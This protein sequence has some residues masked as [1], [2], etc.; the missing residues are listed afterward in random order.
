VAGELNGTPGSD[1]GG[2]VAPAMS[3]RRVLTVP[4]RW[5]P[6]VL[7]APLLVFLVVFFLVPLGEVAWLSISEPTFGFGHYLHIL[8]DPFYR[9]VVFDTLATSLLVTIVC[10]VLAYPLAYVAAQI[11]GA[12]GALLLMLVAMSFWTSFL[13]RTYAWMIILGNRGPVSELLKALGWD[14]PPL[15]LFTRFSSTVA[16]VHILLPIT[17]MAIYAVMRKIDVNTL[18]AAASLGA[19]PFAA[20]RTVYFPLTAAGIVSGSTIVFVLCSG[21]YVTPILI[22]SPREQMISGVIGTQIEEFLAFGEAS[23]MAIVLLVVTVLVLSIY[24]RFF[25]LDRLWG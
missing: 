9:R 1:P 5:M 14:R 17:V 20:F 12:L 18:K 25:G 7:L 6:A 13:V 4:D 2:V 22:G 16:L 8:V 11:G 19:T 10:V 3:R 15:M 24:H 23:A 21:F